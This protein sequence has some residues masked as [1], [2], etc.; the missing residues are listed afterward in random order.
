MNTT[1]MKSV[2]WLLAVICLLASLYVALNQS[3]QILASGN[4]MLGALGDQAYDAARVYIPVATGQKGL[5]TLFEPF[6]DHRVVLERVL[7]IA[8]FYFTDDIQLLQPWRL[9]MALWLTV[10]LLSY[11]I[12]QAK[13]ILPSLRLLLI[14]IATGACFLSCSVTSY[15]N[16]IMLTWPLVIILALSAFILTDKYCA[17]FTHPYRTPY[18][19]SLILLIAACAT[20]AVFTFS[21]GLIIWPIIFMI[22]YKRKVLKL[23]FRTWLICAITC[24]MLYF[25]LH[26]TPEAYQHH[27]RAILKMIKNFFVHPTFYWYPMTLRD[28]VK[29]IFLHPFNFI[30]Y[31]SRILSLPA[32]PTAQFRASFATYCMAALGLGMSIF[33][34]NHYWKKNPWRTTDTVMAAFL[35]FNL[36]AVLI[37]AVSRFWVEAEF[38]S[39][40]LRFTTASLMLWTSL[41]ISAISLTSTGK[42]YFSL[43]TFLPIVAA[44]WFAGFVIP[45]DKY[46][47]NTSYNLSASN[48]YF[49]AL[50]TGVPLD[51]VLID[52]MKEQNNE[53]D[54]NHLS[55]LNDI[56]KRRKKSVYALWQTQAINTSLNS[57]NLNQQSC[58]TLLAEA[59]IVNDL[60]KSGNPAIYI[61]AHLNTTSSSHFSGKSDMLIID[62][63]KKIIGFALPTA[64]TTNL[65]N[66]IRHPNS[67]AWQG[68]INTALTQDKQ[69]T[70]VLVN[71]KQH[72][73]CEINKITI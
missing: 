30:D 24:F 6:A 49:I 43:S 34:L 35:L 59:T 69:L 67:P 56:N 22:L 5:L 70:L 27:S 60:R 15:W 66:K 39:I 23:H 37:I 17:L 50:G 13:N 71:H 10:L 58:E 31:L 36:I 52:S 11:T 12:W 18:P 55:Y 54:I 21:I 68:V 51:R 63:S 53:N 8:D 2:Y 14:S 32:L 3:M 45:G 16:P 62:S 61:N 40:G 25:L 20:L 44:L 1:P 9:V 7:A 28:A 38:V 72:T 19:L 64:N 26:A 41:F 57:L 65:V 33:C 29:N 47:S 48:R 4:Y 42:N 46:L 73:M